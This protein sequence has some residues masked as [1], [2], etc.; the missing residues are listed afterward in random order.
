MLKIIK[1]SLKVLL[2]SVAKISA[3]ILSFLGLGKQSFKEKT[4]YASQDAWNEIFKIWDRNKESFL[5][6]APFRNCPLCQES[7]SDINLWPCEDGYKYV[8]C[9]SCKMVYTSTTLT[10]DQW[11]KYH[12]Q[13]CKQLAPI[14]SSL[15]EI[16]VSKEGVQEDKERFSG[17]L[18][19]IHKYASG[20]KLMDIGCSTGNFLAVAEKKGFEPFG[21]EYFQEAVDK[22]RA[23]NNLNIRQGIFEEIAPQIIN[24]GKKYNV[25]TMWE[26]L[27]HMLFPNDVIRHCNQLLTKDGIVAITVPNFNCLQVRLLREQSNHCLGGP[28]NPGHMNMFT[29]ATLKTILT[30]NGFSVVHFKTEG[31]SSFADILNYLSLNFNNISTYGSS[32]RHVNSQQ[33]A[34]GEFMHP[35]LMHAFLILSPVWTLIENMFDKGAILFIIARKL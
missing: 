2:R 24:T 3:K 4:V 7:S 17:Y 22:G 8:L 1:N 29:E 15:A 12:R 21:I 31:G 30:Q 13:F 11:K 20:K 19:K 9:D 16:K 18:S 23:F 14:Y 35:A 34:V 32:L 28:G 10:Y 5:N 26:T 6:E 25:I 27:E 33:K